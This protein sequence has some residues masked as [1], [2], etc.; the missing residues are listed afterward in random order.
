MI[1]FLRRHQ[2]SVF[3]A[4]ISVFLLSI[5]VG[6]GGMYFTDRDNDGA[7]ARIGGTKIPAQ[8]LLLRVSMYAEA[9]RAKGTEVDDAMM[10]RL[11]R[12]MLNDMMIEEMMP[13]GTNQIRPHRKPC[14][15]AVPNTRPK[16]K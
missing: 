7:V 15:I 10:S 11:K 6:L 1:S 2:K 9:L 5:T 4:T 16:A 3:A 13:N 8:R 14:E 12:E